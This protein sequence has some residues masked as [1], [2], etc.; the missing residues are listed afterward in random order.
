[1]YAPSYQLQKEKDTYL[2]L[3]LEDLCN[4]SSVIFYH[5]DLATTCQTF[6]GVLNCMYLHMY[7]QSP[8]IRNGPIRL[9]VEFWGRSD[10]RNA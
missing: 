3:R 8:I 4:N 6:S 7:T 10:L 5:Q 2:P 1:M 9:G